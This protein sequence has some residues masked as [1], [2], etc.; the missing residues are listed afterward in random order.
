MDIK[1]LASFVPVKNELQMP[2]LG[3]T[4]KADK[5]DG[6]SFEQALGDALGS[7]KQHTNAADT[8][9]AA[10]ASASSGALHENMIALEKAN[11]ALKTM[12]SVRNKVVDAYRELM[13]TT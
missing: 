2:S 11:I 12:V 3:K 5:K 4:E 10:F 8:T 1:S 9:N 13:R 7:V 6:V